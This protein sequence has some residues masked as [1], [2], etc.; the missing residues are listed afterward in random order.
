M[1]A[2][3]AA[4]AVLL[5]AA[6]A[7]PSAAPR[8]APVRNAPAGAVSAGTIPGEFEV[9]ERG[10][11]SYKITVPTPPG[12]ND[13][14]PRLA[15]QYNNATQDG[16]LGAGWTMMGLP[17]V[18]RT[19]ANIEQDGFRGGV[20]YDANDRFAYS[21]QRII[22]V[23]GSEGGDGSVYQ[24]EL[25][26]WQRLVAH[27]KTDGGAAC[28][29]GPCWWSMTTQ[30]G[31][32][33]EFGRT[34]DSR[35]VAVYPDKT[36]GDGSV[37]VWA[38]DKIQDLNGNVMTVT[39]TG[40]PYAGAADAGQYYPSHID[41]TSNA[42]G[43]LS[44]Q[45]RVDFAYEARPNPLRTFTGGRTVVTASRLRQISAS[46]GGTPAPKT[47]IA[48][49]TSPS[50]GRSRITSITLCAGDDSVC[51]PPTTFRW[52]DAKLAFVD[53]GSW[54]NDDFI[55][56]WSASDPRLLYDVNGDGRM[57]LVGF[58][59]DT[60]AALAQ[61]NGSFAKA[62]AWSTGFGKSTGWTGDKTPRTLGDVTGDGLADVV[63]FNYKGVEVGVSTGHSFDKSAW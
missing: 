58:R 39:Y 23:S 55:T 45:R 43:N 56:G 52:S 54:L 34:A 50:T 57:D 62:T 9:T 10:T 24:T 49:Q 30:K 8:P 4:L 33:Y 21:G 1:R 7:A 6:P 31:V 36:T 11:A 12:T 18:Q 53:R 35:V 28:G 38:L 19:G 47:Q 14:T 27:G 25:E 15:L 40:T 51:L 2:A 22:A 41:Y 13:M 60:Q 16:M 44:A 48:Y 42:A 59:L 63:G 46:V 20:N 37:R 29:S 32:T 17:L 61:P 26:S 3:C 5:G